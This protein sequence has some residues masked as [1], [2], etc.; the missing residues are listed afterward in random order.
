MASKVWGNDVLMDKLLTVISTTSVKLTINNTTPTSKADATS[1]EG[2]CLGISTHLD[3]SALANSTMS[4]GGRK[5]PVDA[6]TDIS[7]MQ[8]GTA[9][10]ICLISGST[11]VFVTKCTTRALTT[12]DTASVPAWRIDINDPTT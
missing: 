9:D 7:I 12:A 10:A 1:T 5:L 4:A 3:F 6:T 8:A 2:T 11:L